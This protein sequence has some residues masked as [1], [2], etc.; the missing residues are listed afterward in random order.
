LEYRGYDSAGLLVG[1]NEGDVELVRAVGKVASLSKKVQETLSKKS[2]TFGI[3]HTRR[4]THGGISEENT[5]PHYDMH[6]RFYLVHNG[7]IENYHALK[8]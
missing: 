7:I 8:Q 3:A 1:T 2:R 5:H 4:A 6:K